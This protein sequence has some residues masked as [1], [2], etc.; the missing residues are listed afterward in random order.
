MEINP[1]KRK[2]ERMFFEVQISNSKSRAFDL[3]WDSLNLIPL[4]ET[5]DKCNY[6]KMQQ[7][8]S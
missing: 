8:T 5:S 7:E 4:F 6:L 3:C 2:G 1:V